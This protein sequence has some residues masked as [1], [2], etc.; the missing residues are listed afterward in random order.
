MREQIEVIKGD[1]VDIMKVKPNHVRPMDP[2]RTSETMERLG[3]V[4]V[5]MGINIHGN[6]VQIWE[7]KPRNRNENGI[8]RKA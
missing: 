6:R 4:L 3:F 7:R 2:N 1:W 5:D 8:H